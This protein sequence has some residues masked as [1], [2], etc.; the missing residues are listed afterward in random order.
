LLYNST[1]PATNREALEAVLNWLDAISIGAFCVIGAN[2][3]LR[4]A[5]G[6]DLQVESS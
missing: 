3:G 4:A 1:C 5:N 6:G 2:N